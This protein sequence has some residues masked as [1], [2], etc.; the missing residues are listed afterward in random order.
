M[1]NKSKGDM[2]PDVKTWN[3][4]YGICPHGCIYCYNRIHWSKWGKMRLNERALKDNLGSGNFYFVGSSC[5]MFADDIPEEWIFKVLRR[6]CE[7]KDNKYLFQSKNPKRFNSFSYPDKTI[8]GTTIETNRPAIFGSAP[9]PY[10][11]FEAMVELKKYK[12]DR[13]VSLE[14]IMDFDLDVMIKWM[15]DIAPK[16]ISIG[17]DSKGHNLPEPSEE[18]IK[19][20]IKEL[21]GFTEVKIK[22]N[23]KRLL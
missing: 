3:G 11:R 22:D 17:A 4:M 16:Y 5:D 9:S 2:Y 8:L 23:L 18:K 21:R 14:P 13:M 12:W 20:L 15:K 1:I 6:C 7:F 10:K 19:L